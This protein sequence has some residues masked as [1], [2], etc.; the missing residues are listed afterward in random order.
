M[1]VQTSL[2]KSNERASNTRN[3]KGIG[4]LLRTEILAQPCKFRSHDRLLMRGALMCIDGPHQGI[5]SGQGA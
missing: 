1:N 5:Q 4:L 3:C 2:L